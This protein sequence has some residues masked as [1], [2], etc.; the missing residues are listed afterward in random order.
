MLNK[1]KAIFCSLAKDLYKTPRKR[2][3]ERRIVYSHLQNFLKNQYK[4]SDFDK[5]LDVTLIKFELKALI[6]CVNS[7]DCMWE[8]NQREKPQTAEH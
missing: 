1:I 6:L 2:I 5:D 7:L 8:K 4:E 3:E